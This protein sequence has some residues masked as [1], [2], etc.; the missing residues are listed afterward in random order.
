MPLLQIPGQDTQSFTFR[1]PS[2]LHGRHTQVG[3]AGQAVTATI[4]AQAG[5]RNTATYLLWSYDAI[6]T[7]GQ[8]T[9]TDG[10]ATI[11]LFVTTAGPGF[12]PLEGIAFAVN[13]AVTATL[14]SGGAAVIGSL[15][16]LG[17]RGV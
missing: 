3:T 14:S 2:I 5:L 10:A 7:D 6:P 4:A 12:I 11:T 15:A 9:V 13:T 16:L 8:I 17:V 1:A